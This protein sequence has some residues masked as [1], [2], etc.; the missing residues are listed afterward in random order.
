L[1][2]YTY[3][4]YLVTYTIVKKIFPYQMMFI[5]CNSS[6]THATSAEVTDYSSGT[7][8]FITT[9]KC[10]SCCFISSSLYSALFLQMFSIVDSLKQVFCDN[11]IEKQLVEVGLLYFI[12][13][14]ITILFSVLNFNKLMIYLYWSPSKT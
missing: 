13:W 5:S 10:G 4:L 11:S 8:E 14:Y 12:P 1:H 3:Y 9:F 2:F 6:M 7:P